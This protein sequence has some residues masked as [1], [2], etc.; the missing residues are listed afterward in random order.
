MC[1]SNLIKFT[2]CVVCVHI[3]SQSCLNGTLVANGRDGRPAAQRQEA[4][5][6]ASTNITIVKSALNNPGAHP[7]PAADPPL[8][9]FQ[10]EIWRKKENDGR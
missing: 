1:H 10:E 9:V 5:A 8:L 6:A 2:K 3:L 7:A 4:L